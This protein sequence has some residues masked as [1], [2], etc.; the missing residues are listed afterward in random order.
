MDIPFS[1]EQFI[2]VFVEYNHTIYPAH[3]VAYMLGL[4]ALALVFSRKPWAN[5]I[6]VGI[7]A[8]M[9]I[10]MGAVYHIAFFA[11]INR[12]A[13]FFGA[14]FL[15][16][17]LLL[18]QVTVRDDLQF[19]WAGG[20]Y[21]LTGLGLVVYAMLIYPLLGMALGHGWPRSPMFGVA[22]CPTTI[23]TFGLL[24]LTTNPVPIRLLVVPFLW[25]MIG[26]MAALRLTIY[27]DVGLLVGLV[28]AAMILVRDRGKRSITPNEQIR[29][30]DSAAGQ[31]RT[32]PKGSE[33]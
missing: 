3:L 21:S 28:A 22:P 1:I 29:A 15:L 8:V 24:L 9:W 19:G 25:S 31:S 17:G 5:R 12:G 23:F 27:E 32:L 14:G 18:V 33:T 6:V 11:E 30:R 10:W 2:N 4:D 20:A 7:L 26:F 13:Y 16:H